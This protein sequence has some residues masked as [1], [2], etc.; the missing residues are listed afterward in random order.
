M[1]LCNTYVLNIV[2]L[3]RHS[4]L[5]FNALMKISVSKL[6][7]LKPVLQITHIYLKNNMQYF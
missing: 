4:I 1:Y 2:V 5:F 3:S 7:I 6:T